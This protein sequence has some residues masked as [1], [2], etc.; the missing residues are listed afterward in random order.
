MSR[1][2]QVSLCILLFAGLSTTTA[3]AQKRNNNWVFGLRSWITFNDT[4]PA[5]LPMAYSPSWRNASMSDTSGNFLLM[6]DDSG[7][8]NSMFNLLLDGAP[9]DLGWVG[10][11]SAYLILPK[12]DAPDNYFVF[13]NEREFTKRAGYVE[14][15]MSL[16]GG[17]GG[18][19]GS[20]TIWYMDSTTAKLAA[21]LRS[22]GNGYWILQHEDGSDEFHAFSLTSSGVDVVPVVSHAGSD[23]L[24]TGAPTDSDDYWGAMKFNVQGDVIALV[25]IG[26]PPDTSNT[27]EFY[28][29]DPATAEVQYVTTIY[30][31]YHTLAGTTDTLLQDCRRH[32]GGFDFDSTG[33]HIYIQS[34]DTLTNGCSNFRLLQM[35]LAELDPVAM[36]ASLIYLTHSSG[37]LYW[38]RLDLKGQGLQLGPDGRLIWRTYMSPGTLW[39][40][41]W[42]HEIP[43]V[44]GSTAFHLTNDWPFDVDSIGG[45][46]NLCKRYHDSAPAWMSGGAG[47][48]ASTSTLSVHPNPMN[49][50]ALLELYAGSS[51]DQL[52]WLDVNGRVVRVES[53]HRQSRKIALVRDGLPAGMYCLRLLGAGGATAK[54]RVMLE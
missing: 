50:H 45:F 30:H 31:L 11:N 8:R 21:T 10:G 48:A 29:F 32:F 42:L 41:G 23:F 27:M 13:V 5:T 12:P 20:G 36:E 6:V 24:P 14:V 46:P 7:I 53:I 51:Y 40:S 47:C 22:D 37:A 54:C 26:P 15:D 3:E 1:I 4:A 19:V 34:W 18:V 38:R 25:T 43:G 52:H 33:D 28:R 2:S 9:T 49:E 17:A 16:N 35:D 44:I 39:Q